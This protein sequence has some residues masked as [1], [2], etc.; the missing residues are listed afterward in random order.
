M[1]KIIRGVYGHVD[2]HGF[3]RPKDS[4]SDPFETSP[5]QEERLVKLGVAEYVGEPE[6]AESG[7]EA[8]ADI[9]RAAEAPDLE[10]MTV[11]ELRELGKE[12][13]LTLKVG[14]TKAE[15]AE[16]IRAEWPQPAEDDGEVP[17]TFD[18]AE[19]VE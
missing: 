12:H 6:K 16:A 4:G 8:V 18:A 5:E 1:I 11:K 3:V 9:A 10:D 2:E 7:D 14:M 19:A 17:P 15:M 13:G